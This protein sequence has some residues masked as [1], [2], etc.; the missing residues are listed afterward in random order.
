LALSEQIL[1]EIVRQHGLT[2]RQIT[3]LRSTGV[4][5]S[6]YALDDALVL[7]VADRGNADALCDS[8]TES[9]A[10]P[11]ACA[12]GIRTPR[13][14]VFDNSRG[15]VDCPYTIYERVH[16]ETLG[17]LEEP[18]DIHHA[19]IALGRDLAK[20][21]RQV[22]HVDDP[23]NWLDTPSRID[24]RNELD[25][26]ASAGV[27][28]RTHARWF[29]RWLDRL[30]PAALAP[31]K[32]RFLHNDLQDSNIM[33]TH[34]SYEYL[35]MIDWGDAGWGDAALELQ[36]MDFRA[37]PFVMK[38]Y[39]EVQPFDEDETVEARVLWD[40]I[41]NILRQL[42]GSLKNGRPRAS[43][44]VELLRFTLANSDPQFRQWMP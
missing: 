38:G 9:V 42:A 34:G 5:N 33:V 40:Q 32:T 35:A 8:L 10:V 29:A 43:Y 25:T 12:A 23:A 13:L 39:R 27:L 37:V 22:T 20:L 28:I 41:M 14:I 18:A 2:V 44:A 6:V 24:L 3:P 21:H 17:L 26:L 31:I 16:G 1:R 7:R 15:I 30:A 11:A 19:W 4:V 36:W